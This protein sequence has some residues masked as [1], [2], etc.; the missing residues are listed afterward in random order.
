MLSYQP[1]PP[2]RRADAR[3]PVVNFARDVVDAAPPGDRALVELA[4]DGRRRECSFG[5]VADRRRAWPAPSP[6][7]ASAAATS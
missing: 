1:P 2:P 5:E 6:P 7:A 4:R 3:L